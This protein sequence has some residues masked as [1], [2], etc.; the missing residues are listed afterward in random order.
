VAD[1]PLAAIGAV[2]AQIASG[3]GKFKITVVV[4]AVRTLSAAAALAPVGVRHGPPVREDPPVS[5]AEAGAPAAVAVAV[6][7]GK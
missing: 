7:G 6:A 2:Q 1:S 4:P 5:A 3:I